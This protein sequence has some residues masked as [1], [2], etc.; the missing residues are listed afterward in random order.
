MRERLATVGRRAVRPIPG[1]HFLG[2]YNLLIRFA[3][4]AAVV[5]Y[6]ETMTSRKTWAAP[7]VVA[8][9]AL[10]LVAASVWW[11]TRSGDAGAG[12]AEAYQAALADYCQ[13][14]F[15]LNEFLYID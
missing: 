14:L 13:V 3:P 15:G 11:T 4:V 8:L 7:Y 5:P 10:L 2:I 6:V 12:Q 9:F 1:G